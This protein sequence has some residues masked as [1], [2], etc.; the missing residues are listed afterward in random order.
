M[1]KKWSKSYLI[2]Q[3]RFNL[4]SIKVK[5]ETTCRWQKGF[6]TP[7]MAIVEEEG[8]WSYNPLLGS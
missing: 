2:N 3:N 7:S 5:I 4:L 6:K 1:T 8:F